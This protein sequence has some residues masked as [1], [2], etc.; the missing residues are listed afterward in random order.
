MWREGISFLKKKKNSLTKLRPY[1]R[2]KQKGISAFLINQSILPNVSHIL[3]EN[4]NRKKNEQS[5]RAWEYFLTMKKWNNNWLYRRLVVYSSKWMLF[6]GSR[7]GAGS[8]LVTR[9]ARD[10]GTASSCRVAARALPDRL[11]PRAS[12]NPPFLPTGP[13]TS[14]SGGQGWG[15]TH[16]PVTATVAVIQHHHQRRTTAH[17]AGIRFHDLSG[18]LA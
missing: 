11:V 17:P 13:R 14:S 4:F 9:A 10:K 3:K 12:L 7:Q 2:G 15:Q 18:W 8:D 1:R 5:N 6:T 16:P